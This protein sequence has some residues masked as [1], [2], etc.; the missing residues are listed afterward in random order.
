MA[1]TNPYFPCAL[2]EQTDDYRVICSDLHYFDEFFGDSGSS[3]YAIERLAKKLVREHSITGV[4]FD[5]EAGMFCAYSNRKTPLKKLC[6]KLR[7]ITGSERKHLAEKQLSEPTIS[8][9]KAEQ[10]LLKGFVL[11]LDEKAQKQ[12]LKHVPYPATTVQQ[13]QLLQQ[14]QDGTAEEKIRAAKKINSEARTLVRK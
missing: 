1:T 2:V 8:L 11:S 13:K 5:S 9:D 10:L 12:F 4:K 14:I 6:T 7:L 3:G